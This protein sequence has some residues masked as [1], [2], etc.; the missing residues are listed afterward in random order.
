MQSSE[1]D[2]RISCSCVIFEWIPTVR[3]YLENLDF[4][5]KDYPSVYIICV[6]L[7]SLIFCLE[8]IWI[9]KMRGVPFFLF[10][11]CQGLVSLGKAPASS[12]VSA[13]KAVDVW[14]GCSTF[15]FFFAPVLPE[16]ASVLSCFFPENPGFLFDRDFLAP[17]H[18]G[19]DFFWRE[20]KSNGTKN[21]LCNGRSSH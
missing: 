4:S 9:G 15:E 20:K 18:P 12:T 1:D 11:F 17:N 8:D 10:V 14:C 6:F 21:L 19:G 2:W 16:Q 7:S 5:L 3:L 13:R